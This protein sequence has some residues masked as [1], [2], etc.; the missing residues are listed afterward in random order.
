MKKLYNSY[1]ASFKGLPKEVWWLSLITLINRAGTM[2]IPFL[3]LYLTK[4]RNFTLEQV[5]WIMTAFGLG[6]V[7]GAWLGGWFTDRIGAYRTMVFSLFSSGVF[8]ILMQYAE[9]FW[10]IAFMIFIVVLLADMFRPA[11]FT[12][13]RTYTNEKNQ[14]RST[15][16]IRLAINLGFSAGPAAG[17]FLIY[18]FGYAALFWVDGSTCIAATLLLFYVLSPKRSQ[19]IEKQTFTEAPVS[20]YKDWYFLSFVFGLILFAFAFLQYFSTIPYFYS[21]DYGLSEKYVGLLLAFNGFLIF[22]IEMPVVHYLEKKNSN[23]LHYVFVGAVLLFFSFLVLQIGHH[24]SL[25]WIGMALM[26]FAEVIA[27]PFANSFALSRSKRGRTGQYM[28]LFSISFSIAHIFAHNAGFQLISKFGSYNAWWW[29]IS[30]C[31]I[32]SIIFFIL[33][34]KN[35]QS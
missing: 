11:S 9:Q 32:M 28:A 7:I 29:I 2:V 14:T 24:V 21:E 6:S 18:N 13:L 17:G 15:S 25:L 1:I 12:A 19:K 16:L 5:G 27:F 20:A 4:D 34:R 30:I 10:W 22:L 8:Y 26:S 35:E 3:S 23:T 31:L 33:K